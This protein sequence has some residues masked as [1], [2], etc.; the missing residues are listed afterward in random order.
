MKLVLIFGDQAVGKMT[1]GQK[2]A[3]TT[4]LKLFHG[5]VV[6]EPILELFGEFKGQ[7]IKDI[8]ELI[9]KEFAK[10][11]NYGMIFTYTWAF[12]RQA[13]WD[14]VKSIQKIFKDAEIYY[15]ELVASLETRLE[16]NATP[17]RLK[18]KKSKR[19]LE[20]SNNLI[21]EYNSKYRMQSYDGEIK[22]KNYIK[23]DNTNLSANKVAKMIKDKFDL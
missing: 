13:D 10:S 3:A 18:N 22:F 2:L 8:R 20:L 17:N 14:Y 4:N 12:D 6:I 9:F 15:V 5:H 1:V 16:R 7:L 11:N 21:Y 19:D 23:I